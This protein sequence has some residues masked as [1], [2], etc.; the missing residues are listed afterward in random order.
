M[1]EGKAQTSAAERLFAAMDEMPLVAILRSKTSSQTS[2][3]LL[4]LATRFQ[5]ASVMM[6]RG[7][8][9]DEVVAMGEA[10]VG[11]GFTMIEVFSGFCVQYA[12]ASRFAQVCQ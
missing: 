7:V 8:K 12:S 9:P 10:L 11:A 2:Q 6:I 1:T 3:I 4:A 5:Q